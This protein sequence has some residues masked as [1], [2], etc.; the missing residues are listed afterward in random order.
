MNIV[1]PPVGTIWGKFN[2]R[3]VDHNWVDSLSKAFE[4]R[5]DNCTS[6]S[7]M[8]VA[9]DPD[10]LVDRGIMKT[11]TIEGR[12]IEELPCMELSPEGVVAVKTK[13]LWMLGGHHRRIALMK[14]I[15]KMKETVKAKKK[16]IEEMSQGKTD[17]EIA[18][19]GEDAAMKLRGAKENVKALM[20]KIERSSVWAIKVYDRGAWYERWDEDHMANVRAFREDR[21]HS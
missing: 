6:E 21:K 9:L 20:E 19:M 11:E 7:L 1:D 15:D 10:W 17:D 18:R 5:L 12:R 16:V 8:D 3:P 2:N 4:A 14:H 13:E